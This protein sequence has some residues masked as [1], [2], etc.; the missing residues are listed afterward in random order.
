MCW[1]YIMRCYCCSAKYTTLE[2]SIANFNELYYWNHYFNGS[3]FQ[4]IGLMTYILLMVISCSSK[5]VIITSCVG[6][7]ICVVTVVTHNLRSTHGVILS[8]NSWIWPRR[9]KLITL[10]WLI[11]SIDV[12]EFFVYNILSTIRFSSVIPYSWPMMLV[13]QTCSSMKN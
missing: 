11:P 12:F 6:I 2:N 1:Y 10:N 3:K 5:I 8:S 7:T 9:N 13:F 4:R